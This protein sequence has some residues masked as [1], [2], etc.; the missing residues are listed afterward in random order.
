MKTLVH[1]SG[2]FNFSFQHHARFTTSGIHLWNNANDGVLAPSATAS[3]GMGIQIN[4]TSNTATLAY[5]AVS[6]SGYLSYRGGSHQV[7]PNSNHF[8]GTGSSPELYERTA[9]GAV[10]FHAYLGSGQVQSY[11]AFKYQWSATPAISELS[12]FTYALSCGASMT[13][14]VSWNGA[15]SVASYNF[16]ASNSSIGPFV[17]T[18]TAAKTANFETTYSSGA[19]AL[20]TYVQALDANGIL[21]G[22]TSPAQTFVPST[23]LAPS[24]GATRCPFGTNYTTAATS[25]C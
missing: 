13:Y 19:F 1:N 10:A 3:S 20:Y 18:G 24:C 25:T 2:T 23:D 22:S 17:Q 8:C 11:R 7:L 4:E 14:Y 12:L 16:F 6:P 21:L 5:L 15:T 9:N